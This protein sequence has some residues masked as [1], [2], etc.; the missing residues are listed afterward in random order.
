M[1][2]RSKLILAFCGI[3]IATI[4]LVQEINYHE[5]KKVLLNEL[6]SKV[7]GAAVTT[8]QL[9][10]K[11]QVE[12]AT[13]ELNDKTLNFQSL[14][15]KL[16]N[17]RAA[18]QR[19]DFYLIHVYLVMPDPKNPQQLI[20]VAD[21]SK[22]PS[23]YVGPGTP[24]PEG[25][26]IGILDHLK[27]PFV[28]D[29]E[30]K[31]RWGKFLPAYAPIYSPDGKYLATLGMNLSSS[32]VDTELK[33]LRWIALESMAISLL[34]GLIIAAFLAHGI[35]K[36]L[37]VISRGVSLIGK[38]D[39]QTRI[40]VKSKDEFGHLA[41]AINEMA[42]GLQERD[43]LKS[44]FI[45]YVSKHV[46]ENIISTEKMPELEGE[47][48][49]IT[50]IFSDIRDFT[51]LAEKMPPEDVVSILNEFLGVMLD[52]IFSHDGTLDK[53]MGDGLMVEFGAPLEDKEQET[54]AVQTAIAMQQALAALN[55][56]WGQ[57][58]KPSIS[59]GVGVHTGFAVVGNIG[60]EKRMEYT[61]IGDTVNIASRL[62]EAT[63]ELK[64]PILISG[65]TWRGTQNQFAGK[66]L[67]QL[68]LKGRAE[69]INVY[70]IEH[71]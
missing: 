56:K 60:S 35:T 41:Q 15:K 47:R 17:V 29:H 62:Q 49:K 37:Q 5:N 12:T 30:V 67:G 14:V 69:P 20:V 39:F 44:N 25:K 31:D 45:R 32:Y 64:I 36:S 26:G 46:L 51:R 53:F 59:M 21:A 28:P 19:K 16:R 48:R 4:L 23:I 34:A 22:D 24:Y 70:S 10:D 9:L 2:Y 52:V 55:Q 8:A 65:A 57:E 40:V 7:L 66:D 38:G 3:I 63:K 61:A 13:K 68:H 33:R 27:E 18:N 50:V 43:R 42:K 58:G 6:S 11:A 54:H 1:K 71:S